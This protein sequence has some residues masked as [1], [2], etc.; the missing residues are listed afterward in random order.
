MTERS[1][2]VS[3]ESNQQKNKQ[4]DAVSIPSSPLSPDHPELPHLR[5]AST[6]IS[7]GRVFLVAGS[8]AMEMPPRKET[9]YVD[10][11]SRASDPDQLPFAYR[12]VKLNPRTVSRLRSRLQH[13]L[14]CTVGDD[15]DDPRLD[16]IQ[17]FLGTHF[18]HGLS[19][20]YAPGNILVYWLH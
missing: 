16:G 1:S 14:L 11:T 17:N 5:N 10:A 2:I 15:G 3:E 13:L 4:M 9:Y 12:Q 8:T 20:F 7:L 6:S 18:H 19:G